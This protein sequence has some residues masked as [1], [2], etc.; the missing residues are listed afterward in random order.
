MNAS[1]VGALATVALRLSTSARAASASRTLIAALQAGVL[2]RER[3]GSPNTRFAWERREV[4]IDERVADAA[5]PC[6]PV[7]DV[8][9]IAWL[10]HFAVVDDIDA[11]CDLLAHH[12]GHGL[13]NACCKCSAL[14]RHAFLLRIHHAVR[15]SGRGRLPVWVV[16]KRSLL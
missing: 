11:G 4:L 13:P 7:L 5:D 8:G 3:P 16:R 15:S 10:R 14:D 2:R 9:G 1:R 12:F 6:E